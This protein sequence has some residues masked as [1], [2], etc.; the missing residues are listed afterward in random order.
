MIQN[1]AVKW[2]S[3]TPQPPAPTSFNTIMKRSKYAQH[4]QLMVFQFVNNLYVF[5]GTLIH[6]SCPLKASQCF[7]YRVSRTRQDRD[8]NSGISNNRLR[9]LSSP[10]GCILATHINA[11][12]SSWYTT[13]NLLSGYLPSVQPIIYHITVLTIWRLTA[14]IWVVPHS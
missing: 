8:S 12:Y 1:S 9:W 5:Y 6:L 14:T 13:N 2:F 3:P 11:T 10:D 4:R 7:V